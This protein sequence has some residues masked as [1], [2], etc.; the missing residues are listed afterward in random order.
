MMNDCFNNSFTLSYDDQGLIDNLYSLTFTSVA[1]AGNVS[2]VVP[3]AFFSPSQYQ[4][5]AVSDG[6][7]VRI[8]A[9]ISIQYWR[10]QA[11]GGAKPADF[12]TFNPGSP[13]A[14]SL[15]VVL[16]AIPPIMSNAWQLSCRSLF[17]EP[18]LDQV[19]KLERASGTAQDSHGLPADTSYTTILNNV[20]S[21]TQPLGGQTM[22]AMDKLTV[23]RKYVAY[24]GPGTQTIA[25]ADD[26]WTVN[27][28]AYTVKGFKN[29]SRI[30]ELMSLD[31]ELLDPIT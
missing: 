4:E 22:D 12:I 31:L 16:E 7:Y 26:R 11:L 15:W 18:K 13:W 23:P 9:K 30:D 6:V 10:L 5:A 29:P 3:N 20:A 14:G 19:G 8:N 24:L 1:N 28:Q 2:A 25:Q 17:L 21:W 27:G